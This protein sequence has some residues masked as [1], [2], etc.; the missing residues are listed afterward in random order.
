MAPVLV[1]GETVWLAQVVNFVGQRS[2][3]GNIFNAAHLDPN[4]DD[5]RSFMLQNIWYSQG[6]KAFA[7]SKDAETVPFDR[8]QTDFNGNQFFTDGSRAVMWLSGTPYSLLDTRLIDW[9][10][11][12][13][14]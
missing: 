10:E 5:A 9:D 11:V 3:I 6:L 8:P 13:V 14:Q 1:D 7:Y 12:P 4:T 2:Y